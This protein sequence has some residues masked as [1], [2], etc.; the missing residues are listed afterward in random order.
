MP[1]YGGDPRV[2]EE[3]NSRRFVNCNDH[4]SEQAVFDPVIELDNDD[5]AYAVTLSRERVPRPP[6]GCPDGSPATDDL[7]GDGAS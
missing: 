4:A 5:D 1:I 7:A 6:A 2:G 3:F